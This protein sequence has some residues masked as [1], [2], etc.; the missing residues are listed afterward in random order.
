MDFKS[1]SCVG[2]N[3]YLELL[4]NAIHCY[5]LFYFFIL[6]IVVIRLLAYDQITVQY[7]GSNRS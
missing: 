4:P 1:S 3:S 2:N 5:P 6:K 7:S